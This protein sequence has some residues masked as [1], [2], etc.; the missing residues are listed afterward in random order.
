MDQRQWDCGINIFYAIH[1]FV[2]KKLVYQSAGIS[3]GKI[4]WAGWITDVDGDQW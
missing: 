1:I 2:Y 4:S 3:G